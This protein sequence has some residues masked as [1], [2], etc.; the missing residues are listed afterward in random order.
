MKTEYKE[1]QEAVKETNERNKKIQEAQT[2]IQRD[3]EFRQV[4][5]DVGIKDL[6]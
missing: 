4:M 6:K 1:L 3:K 2:E 5:R